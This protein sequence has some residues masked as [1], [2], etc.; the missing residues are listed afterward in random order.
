MARKK[1]RGLDE[2]IVGHTVELA[3]WRLITKSW[4]KVG[5][6][7]ELLLLHEECP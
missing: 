7:E 5:G 3:G 2:G 1:R 6:K 4:Y